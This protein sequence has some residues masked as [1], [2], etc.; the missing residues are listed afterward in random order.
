M[1][2]LQ[3]VFMAWCFVKHRDNFTI[4]SFYVNLLKAKIIS[5]MNLLTIHPESHELQNVGKV[6]MGTVFL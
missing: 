3:Y 2:T 4:I 6:L 1:S 5:F